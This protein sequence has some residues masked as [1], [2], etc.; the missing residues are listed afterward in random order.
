MGL[1]EGE[2]RDDERADAVVESR[3]IPRGHRAAVLLERGLETCQRLGTR[4]FPGR[5]V[6]R[7]RGRARLAGNLHREDFGLEPARLRGGDG[8][9]VAIDGKRVLIGP[10]HAGLLCGVFGV[11]THVAAAERIP[12][13]IVDHAV[14]HGL[15]AGLDADTHAVDVVR[16][17]RHRLLSAGH[18]ALR[19]A[20]LDRLRG[21]HDRLE[22]R[23]ADLVDRE[24]GNS[25]RQ[26]GM[27][28]RLARRGLSAAT[29]HHLPH[30]HFFDRC[31][32][33]FGAGDGFTNDHGAELRGAERRKAA[34]IA[35]D[36]RTDGR[37]NDGSC[38]VGHEDLSSKG[39]WAN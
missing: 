36:W 23:S 11:L 16:R 13:A 35:S 6:G 10:A 29:L 8:L 17:A 4:V 5:L 32:V 15:V 20:R 39:R 9:A 33:D 27:N 2:R 7:H 34:E 21:K 18:D 24:R 1:R 31:R 12:Q 22:P 25:R 38:G 30:D 19:V 3:R 37:E 28:Q 26:A 14:D